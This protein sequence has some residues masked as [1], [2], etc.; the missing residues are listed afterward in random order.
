MKNKP[1][2]LIAL[3]LLASTALVGNTIQPRMMLKQLS[4][5][6]TIKDWGKSVEV[7]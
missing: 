5:K 2:I 4:K 1:L 6:Q 7:Q 3:V